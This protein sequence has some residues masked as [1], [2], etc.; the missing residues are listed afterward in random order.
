[1]KRDVRWLKAFLGFGDVIIAVVDG[2]GLLVAAST[3]EVRWPRGHAIE[4]RLA[5]S[6]HVVETNS[7]FVVPDVLAFTSNADGAGRQPRFAAGFPIAYHDVT[8][9]ALC[10][11]DDRPRRLDAADFSLLGS[12]SGRV[13]ELLSCD[14]D[15]IRETA[16]MKRRALEVVMRTELD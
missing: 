8:I 7:T 2:A 9:G 3:N 6:R 11:V 10:V 4:D 12:L 1:A 5:L 16:L 13:S 14:P 15:A